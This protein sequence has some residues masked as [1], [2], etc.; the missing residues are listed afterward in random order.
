MRIKAHSLYFGAEIIG[1][2]NNLF[3]E[4]NKFGIYLS[5]TKSTYI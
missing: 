3:V 4:D 5:F 2:F 1:G